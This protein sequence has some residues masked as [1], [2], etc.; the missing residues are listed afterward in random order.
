M[1]K[2]CSLNII[3]ASAIS[4]N[5]HQMLTDVGHNF[6]WPSS[7]NRTLGKIPFFASNKLALRRDS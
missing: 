7:K 2:A 1:A 3:H 6:V 5:K 4:I